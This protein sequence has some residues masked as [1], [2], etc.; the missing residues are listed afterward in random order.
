M[1]RSCVLTGTARGMYGLLQALSHAALPGKGAAAGSKHRQAEEQ[2]YA[3]TGLYDHEQAF[4]SWCYWGPS[5]LP[6]VSPSP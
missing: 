1:A 3:A 4:T 6:R 5:S 2:G